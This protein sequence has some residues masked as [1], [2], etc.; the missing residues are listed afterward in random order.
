MKDSSGNV[1]ASYTPTK[2]ISSL[3][4]SNDQ[5]KEGETYTIY[6]NGTSAGTTDT[7]QANSGGMGGG[8]GMGPGGGGG[9]RP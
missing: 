6:V 3:V 9:Q 4:V 7:S 5:V 1:I 2:A 8:G